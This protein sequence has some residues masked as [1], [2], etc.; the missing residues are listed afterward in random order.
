MISKRSL[1][2]KRSPKKPDL[3]QTNVFF[4]SSISPKNPKD[5]KVKR[6]I[7]SSLAIGYTDVIGI[8]KYLMRMRDI[9]NKIVVIAIMSSPPPTGVPAFFD[10]IYQ[11]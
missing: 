9:G 1:C 7:L 2:R 6:I 5:M 3:D 8:Q 11:I 10:G 4:A